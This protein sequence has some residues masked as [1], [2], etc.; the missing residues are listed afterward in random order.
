VL[1]PDDDQPGGPP[2]RVCT[3]TLRGVYFSTGSAE[4][5]APSRP[6][7]NAVAD[8]LRKHADWTI[9]IEGHTDNVGDDAA[10]LTLSRNRAAAVRNEL[11]GHYAIDAARIRTDG[12]GRKHPVDTNDTADGRAHNRRVEL[13]RGC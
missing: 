6:A 5:L 3:A 4:I 10:N 9:A 1:P 8:M 7:L 2:A 12:F 13:T 11:I